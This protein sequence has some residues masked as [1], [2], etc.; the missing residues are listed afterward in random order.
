MSRSEHIYMTG[1]YTARRIA[2]RS[3]H[4]TELRAEVVDAPGSVVALCATMREARIVADEL[5]SRTNALQEH[6]T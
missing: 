5:A 2:P 6:T 3:Q 4:G 1:A